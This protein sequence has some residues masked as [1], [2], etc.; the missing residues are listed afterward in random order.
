M[1]SKYALA[2]VLLLLVQAC[3]GGSGD[4]PAPV[5][6]APAAPAPAPT[7]PTPTPAPAQPIAACVADNACRWPETANTC[8]QD[9][10][11]YAVSAY[12]GQRAKY[13][14][15]ACTHA[16]NGLADQCATGAGQPGR[17]NELQ[18][19]LNTLVGGDTLYLHPGN[20]WRPVT[21]G[22]HD[23]RGIYQKDA[24]T[25]GTLPTAERPIV[26]TAR[27][28]SRRPVLHS[29][30][31]QFAPGTERSNALPALSVMSAHT[32]IDGLDVVGRVQLWGVT[33]G[34]IQ[35]LDVRYGWGLCDGNWSAIRVEHSQD[36]VVHHNLVRDVTDD[37]MCAGY[38]DRP[39][40]LK[41]FSS[42]RVIWEFNTVR[43]ARRWAFDL[44]RSS[45][46]ATVRFNLLQNAA[47]ALK[48]GRTI[49]SDVYGNVM[50]ASEMCVSVGEIEPAV[51]QTDRVYNN[52]C[53]FANEGY[54]FQ[55]SDPM[56]YA[57]HNVLLENNVM[58]RIAANGGHARFNLGLHRGG[59]RSVSRNAWDS[60]GLY[61]E[62]IY[63]DDLP[64]LSTLGAWQQSTG[65]DAQ[66]LAGPGGACSF[67]DAPSSLT[68]SSFD[69]RVSS[70]N[71]ATQGSNGRELGAYGLANCVGR[72]CLP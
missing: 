17:F 56:Y 27:D 41:E 68:D 61:C 26:I 44:H 51:T 32:V 45:T 23:W 55:Y 24:V 6:P 20:Y 58:S 22:I 3:G 19:A 48:V 13:V 43:N 12:T 49:N 62:A 72:D 52:T 10:G 60:N 30:N 37:T 11:N 50:L 38:D 31:P 5:A 64:C 67:A 1:K 66:G 2:T 21:T 63:D 65:W 54:V 53:V 9:C 47:T 14:D 59:P 69:L 34:R 42:Q 28:S 71:C 25:T 46:D 8:P 15:P 70:A 33:G 4:A 29:Y 39:S 16:G 36:V 7:V 18:A 57:R 40:G 35:N